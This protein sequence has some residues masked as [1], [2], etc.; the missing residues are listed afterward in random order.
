MKNRVRFSLFCEP[1][2]SREFDVLKELLSSAG[3]TFEVEK[4]E[5]GSPI[6]YELR[7][8]YDES[9]L[10]RSMTRCAGANRKFTNRVVSRKEIEERLKTET[11]EEIAESLGVS[12]STLFRKLKAAREY[13]REN[14]D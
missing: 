9:Q 5:E 10:R 6:P 13:D 3:V 7:I 4:R 2:E 14:L 8:E 11:A 1:I 12:R